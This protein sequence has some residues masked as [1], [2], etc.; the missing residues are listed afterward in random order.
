MTITRVI[1]KGR[2]ASLDASAFAALRAP[3]ATVAVDVG[4]GDGR[5]PYLLASE[6]AHRLAIG[7]DALADPMGDRAATAARKPARGG[8]PNLVY[9]HAAVEAL[10]DELAEVA[11]EVYV[12]LP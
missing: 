11:D 2:T 5:F 1:G 6:D 7:I 12:Q 8:R 4:T 9:V 3:Y 10:P